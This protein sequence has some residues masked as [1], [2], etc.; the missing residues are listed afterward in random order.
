MP[1]DYTIVSFPRP[2]DFQLRDSNC[3]PSNSW[4]QWWKVLENFSKSLISFPLGEWKEGR[5]EKQTVIWTALNISS[6]VLIPSVG[7]LN[8]KH[9]LDDDEEKTPRSPHITPDWKRERERQMSQR[10]FPLAD[11]VWQNKHCFLLNDRNWKH[12][13]KHTSCNET[14]K[15]DNR[16]DLR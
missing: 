12:I 14:P 5:K 2:N 11:T 4:I 8:K 1:P 6:P 9:Q 10:S 15:S 16:L 3:I 13:R 7:K